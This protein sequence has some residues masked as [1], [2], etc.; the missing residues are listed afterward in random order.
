MG[1]TCAP[2][3]LGARTLF[4]HTTLPLCVV[5]HLVPSLSYPVVLVTKA[6]AHSC[7]CLL[8]WRATCW[9][10]VSTGGGRSLLSSHTSPC[11]LAQLVRIGCVGVCVTSSSLPFLKAC[12]WGTSLR[13]CMPLYVRGCTVW[14]QLP[15]LVVLFAAFSIVLSSL[16]PFL[17][18][19]SAGHAWLS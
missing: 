18:Q 8:Q 5:S 6:M 1:A 4:M 15:L 3:M 19:V 14:Y 16:W 11:S 2:Y 12:L 10:R 17:L 9:T 7:Q 13:S